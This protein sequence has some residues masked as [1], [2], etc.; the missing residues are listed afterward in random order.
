MN[1]ELLAHRMR[2]GM[3]RFENRRGGV[4][5]LLVQLPTTVPTSVVASASTPTI[6]NCHLARMVAAAVPWVDS[7]TAACPQ[8]FVTTL[9]PLWLIGPIGFTKAE[10]LVIPW[11]YSPASFRVTTAHRMMAPFTLIAPVNAPVYSEYRV[12]VYAVCACIGDI[13][14]TA[15][16][17]TN[18]ICTAHAVS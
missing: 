8:L 13:R 10:L 1:R 6:E 18:S 3:P 7:R 17:A 15:S 14:P 4:L 11:R 9:E 2:H 5:A 16:A 12:I